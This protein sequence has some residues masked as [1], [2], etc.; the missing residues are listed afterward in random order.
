MKKLS[1]V[2]VS[3]NTRELLKSCLD[4]IFSSL[5][6]IK[7]EEIEIWV[8][9]NQSTD[10]SL[11]MI[12][13]DFQNVNAILSEQNLGFG[14]G[15]NLALTKCTAQ[16]I[17]LL[18]PDTIVRPAA[19]ESLVVFL[20]ENAEVGAVGSRLLNPDGTL[21]PSCFPFPTL[22]KEFWRLLHLDL[23]L[24]Y[25]VYDMNSWDITKPQAV[26]VIQGASLMI[27][28][29]VYD[30]VGGFDESY[31]MYTEEVDLC[32]RISRAGWSL[33]WVPG[34]QVLHYGGQSTI[35]AAQDM[36]LNLYKSKLKFFRKYYGNI[37][38][39]IF[40]GELFFISMLR[41]MLTPLTIFENPNKRKN[42]VLLAKRYL[43][44]IS[45]L[46]GW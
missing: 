26:Q 6:K 16:Y 14:A 31:F 25:G 33:Y 39:M 38:G 7:R 41:L 35:Q 30:Q 10:G 17:L 2:I 8:V 18:N 4:S 24:K 27:R 28:K 40:K 5:Q 29:E 20:D 42:H 1:I 44:L 13:A 19:L 15:N 37:A 43:S 12:H 45:S 3:W 32:Y 34:S 11:E 36:F 23:F 22:T 46:P 21:Q 9:D